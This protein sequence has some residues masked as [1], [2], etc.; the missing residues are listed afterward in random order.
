M[1]ESRG[2]ASGEIDGSEEPPLRRVSLLRLRLRLL[3]RLL[4]HDGGKGRRTQRRGRLA[5]LAEPTVD[6]LSAL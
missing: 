2:F 6:W 5:K 1:L 4:L 3:A